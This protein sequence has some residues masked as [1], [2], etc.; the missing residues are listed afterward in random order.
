MQLVSNAAIPA[1]TTK[2]EFR[3]LRPALL[4]I[5]FCILSLN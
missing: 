4:P 3:S 5:G 2:P 1:A